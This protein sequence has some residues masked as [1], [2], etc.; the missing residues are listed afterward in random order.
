MNL[1]NKMTVLRILLVPVFLFFL[2]MTEIPYGIFIATAIFI[3]ASLTDTLDG[4]FAR[5]FNQITRFG[6]FLDPLADKLLVTAALVALV[7]YHSINAWVAFII[8]A[9]EFMISGLRS[10]AASDGVVI[11]ASVWGKVKTIIQI[12]AILLA[13]LNLNLIKINLI[14]NQTFIN[15]TN[16]LTN[17]FMILAV[18]ITVISGIDYFYKNKNVI[19]EL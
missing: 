12:I 2:T 16:I 18:I 3:I 1:P 17:I 15:A 14:E 5:K 13:L 11:A 4:Y 7:E 19:S 10:I 9:R 8:I 6:K